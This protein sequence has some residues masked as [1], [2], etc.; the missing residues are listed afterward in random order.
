M[1]NQSAPSASFAPT[2]DGSVPARPQ[3]LTPIV[4]AEDAYTGIAFNLGFHVLRYDLSLDY[5]AQ[6]NHLR[7]EALIAVENYRPLKQLTLDLSERLRV[8]KVA[9][10]SHSPTRIELRRFRQGQRK[11]VLTF[12]DEIPVD[13]TF[14]LRIT[15]AG[16]PHPLRTVWGEVGWEE[17]NHGAIVANQPNGAPS[18][19]PCDDT[20]DEKVP[21]RISITVDSDL[22]AVANGSLVAESRQ[23]RKTTRV[24]ETNYPMATYLA[25]VYVGPFRRIPLRAAGVGLKQVPVTAWLPE[26]DPKARLVRSNAEREFAQQTDM[27]EFFSTVFGPY[28]FPEYSIVV[29][30]EDMEIPLEA[31][32]MSLFGANHVASRGTWER[33][34][35]H[36]LSHQ[37]FGNSV[38]LVD[39]RDIWLNEGFACYSE[40]LWFEHSRGIPAAAHARAHY[41]VLQQKPQDLLLCDPGGPDMFDDRVYKRGAL[42]VHA[43]RVALGDDMFFEVIQAWTKEHRMGLVETR[44]LENLVV[45]FVRERRP[46]T[47]AEDDI[48]V[49]F[50]D[51]VRRLPLPAFPGTAPAPLPEVLPAGPRM[52]HAN[53]SGPALKHPSP[54][55]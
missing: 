27:V 45:R 30:H 23:G 39:W 52:R 38:G 26:G 24:F 7:G 43:L 5:N 42:T 12:V 17:T 15:Y 35:A 28:P 55:A 9:V 3:R 29:T 33:L 1:K 40:W 50:D 41:E 31:Q 36:E 25:A 22:T 10:T 2:S 47:A 13:S 48:R 44:D 34:I 16:T 54:P 14:D 49:L 6:P 46:Y 20:P 21:F 19:F 18:W 37:W 4:G 53:A 11:L 32:A 51:W 8:S